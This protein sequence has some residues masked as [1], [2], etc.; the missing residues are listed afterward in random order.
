ML[1][2]YREIEGSDMNPVW[3]VIKVVVRR[4]EAVE[5]E[6]NRVILVFVNQD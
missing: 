4:K 6:R 5:F 1:V 2:G 3:L